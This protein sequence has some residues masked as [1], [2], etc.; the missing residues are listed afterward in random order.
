LRLLVTGGAGFIG[1]NFVRRQVRSK[2]WRSIQVLDELTYAGN[3]SNLTECEQD[4]AFKFI[5]GSILDNTL[6]NDL[7]INSDIVVNFA[8]ES[9]VDNSILN[10]NL[11]VMTNVLGTLVLLNAARDSNVETFLQISTDE[12]Y[13]SITTGSWT[14]NSPLEPN[15][16][17]S[18]SK[19]SADL[20]ALSF[21]RTYGMDIRITRS[22]N[23]YG[24]YQFPEKLIPLL[25]TNLIDG[26]KLPIYGNGKNI[27]DW[28]HV[29]DNCAGIEL[30]L[31]KG[32]PG[33]IYNL[34]GGFEIPN[35]D[36]AEKLLD[37]FNANK[38]AIEFVEDRKGHDFRYS[39][40]ND[41]VSLNLGFK[42]QIDF[43]FGI[44]QTIEWYKNNQNW[45]RRLK[46]NS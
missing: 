4:S 23:N 2:N 37:T 3:R 13:G 6:V 40:N 45:W 38:K 21:F 41:K 11:F 18:A 44:L 8:A 28:I 34:G 46:G 15:S 43:E 26:Q 27:R 39:V 12:V 14:E 24:P 22:S 32:V 35:I 1:S 31:E 10:P 17:Y 16:P 7:M 29:E 9:H 5:H 30:V 33:N 36:L 19:A 25:I 42:P 20:L